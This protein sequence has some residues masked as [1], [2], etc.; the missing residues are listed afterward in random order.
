MSIQ[1]LHWIPHSLLDVVIYE[2]LIFA[3]ALSIAR[4]SLN[5]HCEALS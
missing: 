5:E 4:A 3:A 2:A 1:E